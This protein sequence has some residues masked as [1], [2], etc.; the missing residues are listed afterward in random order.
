M[1][2]LI[3]SHYVS[4]CQKYLGMWRI[5]PKSEKNEHTIIMAVKIV[6]IHVGLRFKDWGW[7]EAKV[8]GFRN[9]N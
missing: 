8:W 7:K 9:W 6:K 4:V 5:E 1:M 3:A 2:G